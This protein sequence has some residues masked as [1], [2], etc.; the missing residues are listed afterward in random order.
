[1]KNIIDIYEGIL[2]DVE[3]TINNMDSDLIKAKIQQWI[4]SI[5][6]S[7]DSDLTIEPD[8]TIL[9]T[10]FSVTNDDNFTG[11]PDFIKLSPKFN[12]RTYAP[13]VL[14]RNCKNFKSF[15]IDMPPYI[16][17]LN[18][19]DCPNFEGFIDSTYNIQHITS[20]FN[21]INC[22]NAKF[23]LVPRTMA[24]LCFRNLPNIKDMS[25]LRG[26]NIKTASIEDL[27]NL[28]SVDELPWSITQLLIFRCPRLRKIKYL[29][30]NLEGLYL[31]KNGVNPA[32]LLSENDV[33]RADVIAGKTKME[34]NQEPVRV[35]L[36]LN[37]NENT[38][39]V[40][41][42]FL[43]TASGSTERPTSNKFQF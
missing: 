1:M 27:P 24:W 16:C 33:L 30:P 10:K 38:L 36:N 12:Q 35:M 19:I 5:K 14:I 9:F 42:K 4:D 43:C 7:N 17:Y 41:N 8:N 32:K 3:T 18:I 11:F 15:G 31:H 28:K 29:P 26:S 23:E 2:S 21:I 34:Y 25:C 39:W 6:L 13:S 20:S 40:K 22:A 37:S